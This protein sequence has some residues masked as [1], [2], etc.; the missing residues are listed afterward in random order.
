MT[1]LWW[2]PGCLGI[3]QLTLLWA[4]MVVAAFAI[5]QRI[6]DILS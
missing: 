5:T 4:V 1:Y 3:E 6:V 2:A